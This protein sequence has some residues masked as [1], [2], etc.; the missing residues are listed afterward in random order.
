[1]G[2]RAGWLAVSAGLAGGAHVILVP[3]QPFDID[4]VAA[5]LRHRHQRESFSIVVVATPVVGTFEFAV[6]KGPS[7]DIWAGAI[8]ERV[9]AELGTRTGFESRLVVLGH[10]QRGGTP[11]AADRILASRFG[12]AAVE[13]IQ[14]GA[15]AVMTALCGDDVHLVPLADATAGIRPV[16]DDLLRVAG[17]LLQ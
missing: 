6:T 17:S 11:T 12:V 4:E 16:P 2:H 15:S 14:S 9:R 1:M 8:G 3:E 5:A 10:V 13:A 7:G